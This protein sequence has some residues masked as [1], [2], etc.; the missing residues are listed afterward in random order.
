MYDDFIKS[1]LLY[2]YNNNDI[3]KSII[4][5]FKTIDTSYLDT[6]ID[7][8]KEELKNYKSRYLGLKTRALLSYGI[9]FKK[10]LFRKELENVS[11]EYEG[12]QT[13][14]HIILEYEKIKNKI[15]EKTGQKIPI[16]I[17]KDIQYFPQI[18]EYLDINKL[19]LQHVYICLY[20]FKYLLN[21]TKIL[22]NF[23]LDFIFSTDLIKYAEIYN[24]LPFFKYFLLYQ[25]I[26]DKNILKDAIIKTIRENNDLIL[27]FYFKYM[28][29]YTDYYI[30]EAKS[31]IF[32]EY[33]NNTLKINDDNKFTLLYW[34]D[35]KRTIEH[36]KEEKEKNNPTD[37]Q[38]TF[39]QRLPTHHYLK[40]RYV[41]GGN[42]NNF[43]LK[44]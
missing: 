5:S 7:S 8:L 34:S 29:P 40:S 14:D 16:D 21:D 2:S 22:Y 18:N 36:I 35:T 24:K 39:Q 31:N 41:T 17:N 38:D 33:F 12:S 43:K 9:K 3:F 20:F 30:K 25:F 26:Y 42:K 23:I 4:D 32:N 11:Y 6:K 44:K 15:T 13:Y 37:A 10:S 19:E 27:Y 28:Y 1:I